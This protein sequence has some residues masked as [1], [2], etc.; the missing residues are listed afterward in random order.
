ML[1]GGK[2]RLLCAVAPSP[3]PAGSTTTHV[4]H[5]FFICVRCCPVPCP[6]RIHKNQVPQAVVDATEWGG[7]ARFINHSCDPNC[8][9]KEFVGGDGVS[10]MGIF[11]KR[12]IDL[13]EELNYDYMVSI[14]IV[15]VAV[16]RC[17]RGGINCGFVGPLVC[18]VCGCC[19]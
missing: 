13:G 9:T 2:T 11:A 3:V 5:C 15:W 1:C 12:D 8:Y 16:C 18:E 14:Y 19:G 7:I 17:F 6:R 4:S 10:R